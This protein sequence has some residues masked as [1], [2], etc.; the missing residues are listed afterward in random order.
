MVVG[1]IVGTAPVLPRLV[2]VE[3]MRKLVKARAVEEPEGANHAG[4][5][6]GGEGAAGEADDDD[7]VA[8][9]VV[10]ADEAVGFND[11][12]GNADAEDAA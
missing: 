6:T 11:V 9:V 12:L 2:V 5:R 7:L 4:D 8:G 10:V 1:I 3:D